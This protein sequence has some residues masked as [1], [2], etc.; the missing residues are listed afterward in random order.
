MSNRRKTSGWAVNG[1]GLLIPPTSPVPVRPPVYGAKVYN[2]HGK[3]L[4]CLHGPCGNDGYD[5]IRIEVPHEKPQFIGEKRVYIFCSE[6]CR[7]EFARGTPYE[8]YL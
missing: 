6:E 2:A 3:A 1:S 4:L 7:R 8:H 5:H